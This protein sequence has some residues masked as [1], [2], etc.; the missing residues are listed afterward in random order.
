MHLHLTVQNGVGHTLIVHQ[1]PR[2]LPDGGGRQ[3]LDLLVERQEVHGG[4]GKNLDLDAVAQTRDLI[5]R[6]V[7]GNVHVALLQQELLRG[8]LR[9]MLEDDAVEKRR[10]LE[11]IGVGA[12]SHDLRGSEGLHLEWP[13]PG[14]VEVQPGVAH[15]A[16]DFLC[17][18]GFHVDHGGRPGGQH[19][20]HEGGREVALVADGHDIAVRRHHFLNVLGRPAELRQDEG[21]RPVQCDH[22]RQ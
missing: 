16:V 2:R 14:G 3:R 12:Q 17:H 11:V 4:L 7:L 9:D 8:A 5:G 18:D 20:H 1:I 21:G 13:R 15:V 22:T 19:V 10:A 6:Q